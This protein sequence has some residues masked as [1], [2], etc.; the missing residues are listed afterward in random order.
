MSDDEDRWLDGIEEMK[1]DAFVDDVGRL[2]P[3]SAPELFHLAARQMA[4]NPDMLARL[5]VLLE[6][7]RQIAQKQ[8]GLANGERKS[9]ELA[10]RT[11][12]WQEKFEQL[13]KLHPRL[14]K[15]QICDKVLQS[16]IQDGH[17]SVSHMPFGIAA[18]LRAVK[19]GK[20]VP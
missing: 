20:K 10:V 9:A 1:W 7:A 6:A 18:I 19:V 3:D 16:E 8:A 14:N 5:S 4:A 17:T 2:D 12:R 11:I 13:K 15:E